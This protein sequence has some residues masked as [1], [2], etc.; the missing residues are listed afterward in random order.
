MGSEPII[1]TEAASQTPQKTGRADADRSN[2]VDVSHVV[3]MRRAAGISG[4]ALVGHLNGGGAATSAAS[5][6]ASGTTPGSSSSS[7]VQRSA[8]NAPQ[9]D[10]QGAKARALE[11]KRALLDG[12]TEDEEKAL[13]QIRGQS[14]VQVGEIRRQYKR[15]TGRV[16]EKDFKAYCNEAQ[17]TEALGMIWPSMSLKEKIHANVSEGTLWNTEN[18]E[19]MLD[20]L[21]NA[22]RQE[23]EAI[24]GDSR[25]MK[26]LERSLNHDQMFEARKLIAAGSGTDE[27]MVQAA[28]QR[29][30]AASGLLNDDENAVW[31]ALLDLSVE[32]RRTL[33][34]DHREVFS[35]MGGR[36]ER[37]SL[38]TICTGTQ[39]EA[40][41]ERLRLATAGAG[42]KDDAVAKVT[43]KTGE[44]LRREQDLQRLLA[45]GV[46]EQGRPLSEERKAAIQAELSSLGGIR[47][48]LLTTEEVGGGIK[49]DSFLGMLHGDV[50]SAEFQAFAAS[51][52]VMPYDRAKR[53][54]IDAF[55]TFNDDEAKIYAAFEQ[56]PEDL[57][58]RLWQDPD[59][60]W[61]IQRWMNSEEQRRAQD[62]AENDTFNIALHKIRDAFH[63]VNTDE[64]EVIK[65]VAALSPDDR[66]RFAAHTLWTTI[67]NSGAFN[68]QEKKIL[69]HLVST[70]A[71]PRDEVLHYALGHEEGVS[72]GG[73][74]GEE[75]FTEWIRGMSPEERGQ[76]RFGFWISRQS[77]DERPDN[78]AANLSLA[79]FQDLERRMQARF[80]TDDVQRF[81]DDILGP[82]Q[83]AD[84][85]T[86]QGRAMAVDIMAA[87][88]QDKQAL[89]GSLGD[90]FTET[91]ETADMASAMFMAYHRQLK[92]DGE[93]SVE[94]VAVLGHLSQQYEG[95]YDE[96]VATLD[97]VANIAG[98]V[99]AIAVGI[100]VTVLSGGTAGPVVGSLLAKYAVTGAVAG[101]I[102]KV[103]TAELLAGDHY[104][105]TGAEGGRDALAGA[106]D[107]AM[108]VLG[109]G[110]SH[111]FTSMIGLNR[112]ALAAEMT[113]GVLQSTRGASSYM[114]RRMLAGG[115]E[116]SIDGFL[117]GAVGELVL[118]AS[119]K[120]TWDAGVWDVITNLGLAMLKGG[121]IGAG[122][123][124]VL[125][126]SIDGVGAAAST[127][128]V[129]QR[130]ADLAGHLDEAR[131][132]RLSFEQID[133]ITAAERALQ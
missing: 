60:S 79:H 7:Q 28:I 114:G 128:R 58:R 66:Q 123:G 59:V 69:E 29:I 3:Q 121:L 99:A 33:W 55:G 20:A 112:Q 85:Q 39:A 75:M 53:Q 76:L 125:G 50:S 49:T 101:A 25:L 111:R 93:V 133:G 127:R 18:E 67:R 131:V 2:A 10:V 132:S 68:A 94:D 109:A 12:F 47:D 64:V 36:S 15:A 71:M 81:L 13:N 103:G 96:Y 91:D 21:R 120:A 97:A 56:L 118:K 19:G 52:G 22:S 65:L 11:I 119:D 63:G 82:P 83:P 122:T 48:A 30:E 41:K 62:N 57:R 80:G 84:L 115:L 1:S 87:R 17:A 45:G 34:K 106:A 89:Q 92:E 32:Q 104:E 6:T 24:S 40:L 51:M 116:A 95:R 105:A 98:T 102:A 5:A 23:L 61:R 37:R 107:G 4:D 38:Q 27:A 86:A 130:A 117:G 88:V 43:Q 16:L 74:G 31:D 72:G 46:D 77:A 14:S 78:D 35:F 90:A 42:T 8:P 26:L 9:V 54:I 100:L 44:A 129:N 110:L 124:A 126:G 73:D 108:A 113:A 70:G